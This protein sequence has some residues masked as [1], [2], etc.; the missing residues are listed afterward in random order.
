M[1][2]YVGVCMCVYMMQYYSVIRKKEILPFVT[3]LMKLK[4]LILSEVTQ[5]E[6]SCI[7][8][9]SSYTVWSHMQ[10]LEKYGAYGNSNLV[11]GMKGGVE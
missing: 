8:I 3:T 10:N 7:R 11:G 4:G 1:L 9:W 6:K 2:C 5:T